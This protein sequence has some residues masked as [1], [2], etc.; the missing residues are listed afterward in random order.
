MSLQYQQIMNYLLLLESSWLSLNETKRHRGQE[1]RTESHSGNRKK[2]IFIK[3]VIKT[4]QTEFCV[5]SLHM[6][7][8]LKHPGTDRDA[9]C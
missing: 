2:N 6:E 3:E 5:S 9:K 7:Q 1:Q 8:Y 4:V